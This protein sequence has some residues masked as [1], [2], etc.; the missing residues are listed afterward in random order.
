MQSLFSYHFNLP[1]TAIA[2]HEDEEAG[3][4]AGLAMGL[5]GAVTAILV[6]VLVQLI[7]LR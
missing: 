6:P 3:A 2:F 1:G 4:F 5:N 7:G